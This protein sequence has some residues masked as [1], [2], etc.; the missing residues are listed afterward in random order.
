MPLYMFQAAYTPEAWAAL[1]RTPEDRAQVFRTLAG[2]VGARLLSVYFCF[3]EYDIVATFEA[4]D[5]VTAATLAAT[6]AAAGHL[7]ALTTTPLLT[8]DEG[9]EVMR[10][11]GGLSYQVPGSLATRIAARLAADTRTAVAM[12]DVSAVGGE[13][14]LEGSVPAASVKQAAEEIARAQPGVALVLNELHVQPAPPGE[15]RP[16]PQRGTQFPT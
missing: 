4:P 13:V 11:A 3:G 9:L 5:A 6:V 12:I 10:R 2:R 1:T 14:T 7:K 15:I 16:I 8:M